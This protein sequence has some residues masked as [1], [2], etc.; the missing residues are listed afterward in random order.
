[1]KERA[2]ID[3]YFNT[4]WTQRIAKE[5]GCV[6]RGDPSG[7]FCPNSLLISPGNEGL[8]HHFTKRVTLTA[9]NVGSSSRGLSSAGSG[10]CSASASQL[11]SRIGTPYKEVVTESRRA[12]TPASLRP[13]RSAAALPHGIAGSPTPS[14]LRS[15]GGFSMGSSISSS[16]HY[17]A[18]KGPSLPSSLV[19]EAQKAVKSEFRKFELEA[20]Q[21]EL[22]KEVA[23]RRRAESKLMQ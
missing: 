9:S 17:V 12:P 6:M 10:L 21:R 22:N 15:S 11:P 8:R 5:E 16:R 3:Q 23:A 2:T 19:A 13:S 7:I 20:L 1:M 14:I 18:S 4:T